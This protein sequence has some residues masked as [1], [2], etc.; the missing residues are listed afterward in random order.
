VHLLKAINT[1]TV[2]YSTGE[3]SE[4]EI[5]AHAA[6][7]TRLALSLGRDGAEVE[8]AHVADPSPYSSYSKRVRIK[9][10]SGQKIRFSLGSGGTLIIEG[11]PGLVRKFADSMAYFG[12][13]YQPDEHMHIDYLGEDHDVAQGSIPAG[14]A[15]LGPEKGT[16]DGSS[17]S[18]TP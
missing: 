4:V 7:W 6:E 8:C 13:H 12:D 14:F 15:H 3:F 16:C 10:S 18:P 1:M 9:H 2:L 17:G 11:D 5:S